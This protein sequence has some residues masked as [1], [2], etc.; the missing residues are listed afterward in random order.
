[1]RSRLIVALVVLIALTA[2]APAPF[3]KPGKKTGPGG[4]QG[5]WVVEK[6]Q[7]GA[8]KEMPKRDYQMKVRIEGDKWTFLRV[9]NGQTTTGPGYTI[10]L[11]KMNPTWLDLK[12]VTTAIGKGKV[13]A[14][15]ASRVRVQGIYRVEDDTVKFVYTAGI[16]NSV[17]PTS[18]STLETRQFLMVLKREKP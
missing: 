6:Q 9:T 11:D 16:G 12:A 17:R 13:K 15:G 10:V 8:G 3:P 5:T 14:K 1:M 18:F 2:F 7:S 4:L